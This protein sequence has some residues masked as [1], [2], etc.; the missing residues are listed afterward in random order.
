MAT[1]LDFGSASATIF[2]GQNALSQALASRAATG[3]A[4][5]EQTAKWANQPAPSADDFALDVVNSVWGQVA[6]PWTRPFLDI[7]AKS[8]GT[9]VYQEDFVHSFDAAR[10]TIN[11]WVATETSNKIQNLLPGGSVTSNTR[12]VLVN[13]IHLKLPWITPFDVS[14]TGSATFTKSD[15]T[16][17]AT[18]F[19]NSVGFLPYED[20]GFAQLV[21]IPLEGN[22]GLVVALPHGDLPTYEASLTSG[23]ASMH[24]PTGSADVALALPKY[25]FTST[26]FSLAT[27]LQA[28]GMV[29]AFEPATADLPAWS[30]PRP[31]ERRST[32][33]TCCKR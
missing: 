12:M 30:R 13:A 31:T 24:P 33:A 9:G 26:S 18:S 23:A 27:A 5:A 10:V 1:A 22:V 16:T 2:D 25:D 7:L 11:D 4:A 20:D 21:E 32:W 19:M 28:M 29:Q 17:E 8:Y 15:G 14:D 3:L 6:Y